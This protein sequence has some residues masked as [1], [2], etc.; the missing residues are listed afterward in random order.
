[1]LVSH[2]R[3]RRGL[4]EASH[5]FDSVAEQLITRENG[6]VGVSGTAPINLVA[7][8]RGIVFSAPHEATMAAMSLNCS[9]GCP[10]LVRSS[11]S[12]SA[13]IGQRWPRLVTR[14]S[15]SFASRLT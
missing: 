6:S 12:A 15:S 10:S 8:Q 13:I 4:A 11:A 9:D 5:Q 7:A 2:R 1:M 14:G 3:T